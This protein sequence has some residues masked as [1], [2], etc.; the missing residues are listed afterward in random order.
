MS[1][2]WKAAV[3]HQTALT[4]VPI[5]HVPENHGGRLIAM[6]PDEGPVGYLNYIA[7]DKGVGIDMIHVKP[8][9]RRQ[10][11]AS[12]LTDR[13]REMHPGHQ[14]VTE[15]FSPLGERWQQGY[16]RSRGVHI[17]ALDPGAWWGDE[18]GDED[19]FED[20]YRDRLED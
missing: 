20:G 14:I 7:S 19:E 6:H 4:P 13:L 15:D 12:T 2:L 17:K 18:D 3:S 5:T 9:H 16:Q 1:L 10:G 11:I 8:A